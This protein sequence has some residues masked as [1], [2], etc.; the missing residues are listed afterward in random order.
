MKLRQK[1][2]IVFGLSYM[3]VFMGFF[4]TTNTFLM[5]GF[6]ELEDANI[7]K[8]TELGLHALELRMNELDEVT[9]SY[10]A[11]D[12]AY[13]FIKS[14]ITHFID[15]ALLMSTFVESRISFMAFLDL[16][17]RVVYTKAFDIMRLRSIPF[18]SSVMEQITSIDSL[19]THDRV[20][21]KVV[22]LLD[23]LEGPYM[24]ASRPIL[25]SEKKGPIVGTLICGRFIDT[26]EVERLKQVTFLSLKLIDFGTVQGSSDLSSVLTRLSDG[27]PIVVERPS[28][29][30]ILSY[31]VVNTM[32]GEPALLLEVDAARDVF[33]HS[34]MMVSYFVVTSLLVGVVIALI[35][36]LTMNR[37]ILSPLVKLSKEVSEIDP[38]AIDL[39]NVVI[40]GDDELA[41]L[42]V[43]IDDMLQA[44]NDYQRRLR[45]SER[46]ATIGQTSA[47]VG[48]DLRNPLQ[49]VYLLSARLKKRIELIRDR[50]E[51]ADVKELE[52]IE[53]K[54]K[55]QTVYM[56]KIVSDLQDFSKTVNVKPEDTDLEE[57]AVDV[58]ASI[59]MPENVDVS[60]SFDM[61]LH[62]IYSD[63]GLLRR[64]FTNLI[65]NAVQAMPDGGFLIVEGSVVNEMAKIVVSDTGVGISEENMSK[66]FQPLFTT[67]AKGTGLGLAVCKKIVEAHGGEIY[68][69]SKEDVGS[70]F[71]FLIPYNWP[72]DVDQA[73]IEDIVVPED[74]KM[75]EHR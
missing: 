6:L 61:R 16:N 45:E 68:V 74:E 28:Y 34:L 73:P 31:T 18:P 52:F 17:G 21:D 41:A 72:T 35:A 10:A 42:S 63:G 51:E 27:A 57:I 12:N 43:N 22:G 20:D 48:H 7:K 69:S 33:Q 14:N 11:W 5:Q 39:R 29:E 71:T 64:V 65:T 59:Q 1:L 70:S 15:N 44:L 37:M 32:F 8:Q 19:K 36:L 3:L 23:S 60:V 53:D 30:S 62:R 26:L 55:S 66:M 13:Y 49:V 24:V 67:K 25:T 50:L 54:L 9:H 47:M 46:M 2:F 38:H 58:I 4:L 40:K 56:D 75:A